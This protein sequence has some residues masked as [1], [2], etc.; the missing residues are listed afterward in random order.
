MIMYQKEQLWFNHQSKY[1]VASP[2]ITMEKYSV[3]QIIYFFHVLF[4]EYFKISMLKMA[5]TLIVLMNFTCL[6]TQ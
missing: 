6:E 4:D 3:R 2:H 1:Q 5:D